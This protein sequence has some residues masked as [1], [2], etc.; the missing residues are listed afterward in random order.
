VSETMTYSVPK[1]HCA[2]CAESIKEE[3]SEVAGVEQVDVNIDTKVVTISGE[4]LA[5]D[6]LRAAIREAGYEA[7]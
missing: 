3:V 2:H 7:A 1:I 4:A 5:D 6:V